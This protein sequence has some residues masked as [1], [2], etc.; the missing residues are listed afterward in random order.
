VVGVDHQSDLWADRRAH[1]L[2]DFGV[3]G[4]PE[5]DLE[6]HRAKALLGVAGR[7]F[8]EIIPRVA[9][10][11]A[12]EAGRVGADLGAHRSAH[13]AVRR[14]AE[15]LALQ[16]PQRDVDPGER[17]HRQALLAVVAERRV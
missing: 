16:V 9:G 8:G 6:L 4:D 14:D 7:L 2:G 11:A 10:L 17:L 3:L 5:A 15:V 12:V 1:R 13:Q